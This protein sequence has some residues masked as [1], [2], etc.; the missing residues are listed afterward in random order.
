MSIKRLCLAPNCSRFRVEGS[1]Y[2]EKHR[3][4]Y[5][6]LEEQRK[7]EWLSKKYNRQH[8][9]SKYTDLYATREWKELRKRHL[10]KFPYCEKCGT[11]Y[12]LQVHHKYPEGVDYSSTEMFFN[13]DA[14][15]TLCTSCHSK[16]HDENRGNK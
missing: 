15:E 10:E 8:T 5:E 13:E 1:K 7:K 6:A 11:R 3:E 14:L 4:K 9:Q 2:C 16:T 12:G